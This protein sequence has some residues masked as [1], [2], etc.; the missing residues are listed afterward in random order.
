MPSLGQRSR[1]EEGVGVG[2]RLGQIKA[3]PGKPPRQ[4]RDREADA[5]N[6]SYAGEEAQ[7]LPK[8]VAQQ[9]PRQDAVFLFW[10][11]GGTIVFLLSFIHSFSVDMCVL[12]VLSPVPSILDGGENQRQ[13]VG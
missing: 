1:F 10:E 4:A 12:S 5:G 9:R 11:S 8:C 6:R 3:G 13:T 7:R 2:A